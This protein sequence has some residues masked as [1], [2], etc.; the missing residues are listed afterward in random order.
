MILIID[1]EE[2]V[3]DVASR[4][5]EIANLPTLKARDGRE[6]I[7]LLRQH[8]DEVNLIILDIFMPG[9]SGFDILIMIKEINPDVR[10]LVSSGSINDSTR[11][12]VLSMGATGFISKPYTPQELIDTV[13]ETLRQSNQAAS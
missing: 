1:D 10:I 9:L 11:K 13:S 4:S 2:Y 7:R 3:L 5:L 12:N 6:G 8:L